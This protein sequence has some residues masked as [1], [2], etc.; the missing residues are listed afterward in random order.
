MAY[1]TVDRTFEMFRDEIILFER[2]RFITYSESVQSLFPYTLHT[3]T[4]ERSASHSIVQYAKKHTLDMI[5]MSTH[6]RRGIQQVLF[7]SM[8]ERVVRT[9]P[10]PVLTNTSSN[11]SIGTLKK[12][13]GAR[14]IKK[15]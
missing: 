5:S 15:M 8:T 9:A 13:K 14:S 2:K 3:V 11:Y 12:K 10:C 6:G 4:E 1:H 7:G